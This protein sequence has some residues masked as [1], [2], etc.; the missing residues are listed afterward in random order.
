MSRAV[1]LLL[2]AA[3]AWAAE[4]QSPRVSRPAI[5]AMEQSFDKR[6][7]IYSGTAPYDLLGTTRGIYL[8]GCGAIFTAELN[9]L[10]TT[11]ISPFHL[12]IPRED[13]VKVHEQKLKRLPLLKQTMQQAMLDMAA[14]LDSVPENESIVLAVSLFYFHKWEDTTGLPAQIIMRAQRRR[15]LDVHLGRASRATLDSVIEVAEL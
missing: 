11:N 12:T 3:A 14:S 9:L 1:C 2:V 7:L 6:I 4:A 15:L 8:D 5:E 10:V 13:V